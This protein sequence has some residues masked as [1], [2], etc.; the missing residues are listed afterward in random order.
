MAKLVRY[1]WLLVLIP[2]AVQAEVAKPVDSL[3]PA[4]V[5]G[6]KKPSV[7]KTIYKEGK[8]YRVLKMPAQTDTKAD[9]VEVAEV[10]WYGCPHCYSLEGIVDAWK[11]KLPK[12]AH[13]VRV[14]AFYGPNI[15]KTHA[16]LYYTLDS[17]GILEKVHDAVFNEIQNK[18]NY[19]KNSDAM[20]AFLNKN[21]GVE[22]AKFES[23]FNSIGIVHQLLKASSMI[24]SYGLTG[25]PAIVVDGRYVVEPRLAGS[26]ENMTAISDYL[27][28]K[29]KAD[30]EKEKAD[31]KLKGDK[32]P[33]KL[34]EV[35]PAA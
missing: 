24:R 31:K 3:K 9:Q 6:D 10:F 11:P 19:L 32:T 1:L 29:V 33:G 2:L 18:K 21:Y 15:W 30:R 8:D 16:Q 5:A 12:D 23:S 35:A 34:P 7:A 28:T 27:I 13:F 4:A 26:L 20:A 25:V 17:M 22:K 14:P